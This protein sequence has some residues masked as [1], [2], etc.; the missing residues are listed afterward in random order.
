[1]PPDSASATY[2]TALKDWFTSPETLIGIT[3]SL[4]TL[5]TTFFNPSRR[6]SP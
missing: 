5:D 6:K 2:F 3:V 4:T 1:M